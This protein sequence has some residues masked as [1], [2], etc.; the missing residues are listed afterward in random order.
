MRQRDR[1]DEV[2]QSLPPD[3]QRAMLI[4][5]EKGASFFVTTLPLARYGFTLS[6]GEFLD[7]V[8]LRYMWPLPNLP[9]QC[10]CGSPFSVDHSQ[11]CHTGGFINMRHDAIR[12]LLA[13]EM[14]EF[15]RDVQ[16][17]PALTPL[18]GEVI[19]PTSANREPDARGDIRAR[20]FWADQQ[21]AY[22]DIRV[23]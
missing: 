18:S 3:L 7:A 22:F 10:V 11:M 15:L 6:K 1:A 17:E 23:F 2:R 14:R 19:L 4:S 12:D 8:L 20:G 21:S 16:T 13:T 5:Q 9:A